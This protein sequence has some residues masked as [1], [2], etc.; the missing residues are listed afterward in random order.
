MV[1]NEKFTKGKLQ[2]VFLAL[3]LH[4]AVSS[5]DSLNGEQMKQRSVLSTLLRPVYHCVPTTLR[6]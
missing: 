5:A 2:T 4:L 1:L 3:S 6:R